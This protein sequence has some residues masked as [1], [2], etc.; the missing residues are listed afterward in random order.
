[1]ELIL[2]NEFDKH[3]YQCVAN[4]P[5]S[6]DETR[7][8]IYSIFKSYIRADNDLSRESITLI[9]ADA[10]NTWNFEELQNLGDWIFFVRTI[11]P[12]SLVV[13]ADYYDTIARS[14]YYRCYRIL[15]GKWKVF[16]ELSDSMPLFVEKLQASNIMEWK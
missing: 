10:R 12:E 7:A 9:Y 5:T 11:F 2:Q 3:I 13:S 16:E 4:V 14:S 1:M 8:Y 15:D 6:L